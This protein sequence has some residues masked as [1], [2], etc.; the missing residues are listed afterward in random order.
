MENERIHGIRESLGVR[1][2]WCG[3]LEILAGATHA[4]VN[5]RKARRVGPSSRWL[6]STLA[7]LDCEEFSS[8]VLV[9]S[10]GSLIYELPAWVAIRE[11]RPLI[12]VMERLPEDFSEAKRAAW[13]RDYGAFLDF[14]KTL[15]IAPEARG[16]GDGRVSTTKRAS[17]AARMRERDRVV[18][19]LADLV[20]G[21]EI[22][23]GGVWFGLLER[24]LREGR[25]VVCCPD[26]GG[27]ATAG[28]RALLR[29]GPVEL[30][31]HFK[32]DSI[33]RKEQARSAQPRGWGTRCLPIATGPQ[34]A[35][36]WVQGKAL[37]GDRG[38]SPR[39]TARRA[40]ASRSEAENMAEGQHRSQSPRTTAKLSPLEWTPVELDLAV[41]IR[42]AEE[43][44][45]RGALPVA[46]ARLEPSSGGGPKAEPSPG[47][48]AGGPGAAPEILQGGRVRATARA[49]EGTNDD[50][51]HAAG[52][53]ALPGPRPADYI[54]HYTREHFGP[55]PGESVGEYLEALVTGD[56]SSAHTALDTLLRILGE[57]RIRASSKMIRGKHRVCCF[58]DRPPW[59]IRGIAAWDRSLCRRN[60]LPY[61]VGFRKDY[62]RRKGFLP[63]LHLPRSAYGEL[64]LE[65]R[66]RFQRYEPPRCDRIREGEWR[67]HGDLDFS[68]ARPED[69]LAIVPSR[70]AAAR[71]HLLGKGLPVLLESGWKN[72]AERLP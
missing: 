59:E 5:S 57:E 47:S 69:L 52:P 8:G 24:R 19:G 16:E 31:I 54:Y 2:R 14:G 12:L 21:V 30:G 32:R 50:Q 45:P 33:E 7:A 15:L 29:Q 4:V 55:W 36:W 39:P 63:V 18:D 28:N 22:R 42:G 34:R 37:S 13:H 60:F 56:P 72:S 25:R 53:A 58:S 61:A 51:G 17:R 46:P 38:Q 71:V 9:S 70:A 66:F 48:R 26:R 35:P 65:Q 49:A 20:C 64:S 27:A 68:D 23:A 41:E 10:L 1:I 44:A 67:C 43:L 62:A 6:R 3:P 40:G 11:G